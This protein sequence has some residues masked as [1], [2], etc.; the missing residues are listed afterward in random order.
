MVHIAP[1]PLLVQLLN[2]MRERGH[3]QI[4]I[5]ASLAGNA[6]M[7][8]AAAYAASKAAVRSY[9]EALRAV[10]HRDGVLVNVVQP[11]FI[12]TPMTANVP[13]PMPF[14]I[15]LPEAGTASIV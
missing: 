2:R 7:P 4:V 1:G 12:K 10:V 8:I 5:V 6:A 14:I 3:G 15:D 9:G 13:V 11:G